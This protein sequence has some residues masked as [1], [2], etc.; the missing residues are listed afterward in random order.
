LLVAK[1]A[2]FSSSAHTVCT[3][4]SFAGT[5]EELTWHHPLAQT[6]RCSASQRQYEIS[7]QT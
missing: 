1:T 3:Q 4:L 5:K 7:P 2:T 6:I